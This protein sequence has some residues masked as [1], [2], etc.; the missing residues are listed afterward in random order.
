MLRKSIPVCLLLAFLLPA[1]ASADELTQIIQKDL[2]ALGYEPGNTEGELSTETIVAISKFQAENDLDVTGEASPQLAG[3]IKAKVKERNNPGGGMA[4][5][6]AVAAASN[7][8]PQPMDADSLQA[9]QQTCLQEK[10]EA[11][12]AS[13]KKKRGFGS[14]MRAVTNTA[15]RFGGN[16]ELARQVRDTSYDIYRVDATASDWERAADDLGLTQDELEACRNPQ[17]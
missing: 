15:A 1:A 3:V 9:A 4:N 6:P 14:L 10:I 17:M 13:Q 8:G 7:A 16:S 12:Q 5:T 11:A 2:I